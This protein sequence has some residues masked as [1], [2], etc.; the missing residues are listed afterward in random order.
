[1]TDPLEL[2]RNHCRLNGGDMGNLH[3]VCEDGNMEDYHIEREIKEAESAL[4]VLQSL[5]G[6][7]TDARYALYEKWSEE[8]PALVTQIVEEKIKEVLGDK[9]D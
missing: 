8:F 1:M 7:T 5:Q 2:W 6:M 4:L 3:A 9:T